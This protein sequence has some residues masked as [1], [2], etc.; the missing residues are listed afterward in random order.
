MRTHVTLAHWEGLSLSAFVLGIKQQLPV[1]R[2]RAC[3]DGTCCLREEAALDGPFR[4]DR[5][6]TGNSGAEL[7]AF[8]M[9]ADTH[10]QPCNVQSLHTGS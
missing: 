7:M 5:L 2:Y 8:S 10:V 6:D 9:S 1:E 4:S 3:T